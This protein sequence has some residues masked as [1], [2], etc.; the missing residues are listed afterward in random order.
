MELSYTFQNQE[1]LNLA[2][3]HT[4]LAHEKGIESNQRLEFLGDSILSFVVATELYARFPQL[5]EGRLT[6]MRAA[7]VCEKSLAQAAREMDL[8]SGIRFGKSETVCGGREKE[9]I[10]ADAFEAVLGA[11]YLDSNMDVAREWVLRHLEETIMESAKLDFTNYKSELQKYYQKRDKTRDVVTYRL[12]G[13]T[14][15]DHQPVFEAEAVYLGKV[16]G[17][18]SG[19]SRKAAEQQAAKQAYR[20]L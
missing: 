1:L 3:T 13:Q 19:N 17:R 11:I 14:G 15:P 12:V 6:E 7:A 2:L 8:G 16:I 4:S 10:L 18:G 5:A 20:K 9:S